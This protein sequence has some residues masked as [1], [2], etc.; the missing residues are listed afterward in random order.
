MN[1]QFFVIP[2]LELADPDQTYRELMEICRPYGAAAMVKRTDDDKYNIHVTRPVPLDLGAEIA[3][4]LGVRGLL[5]YW[6]G[7]VNELRLIIRDQ[8]YERVRRAVNDAVNPK[9][10]NVPNFN[11]RVVNHNNEYVEVML[12]GA[13]D[14]AKHDTLIFYFMHYGILNPNA[15][16]EKG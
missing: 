5:N 13:H 1:Q 3:H 8:S 7:P 12:A 16:V 9:L 11:P 2:D 10:A 4:H 15:D 14:A 6:P